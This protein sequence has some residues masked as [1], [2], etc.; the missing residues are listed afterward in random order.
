M[1]TVT[2]TVFLRTR[3]APL[4]VLTGQNYMS[5]CFFSV[6]VLFFNGQTELTIAV[7]A[8]PAAALEPQPSRPTE[9]L[10]LGA[11]STY[12]FWGVDS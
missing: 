3:T 5:V 10:R 2:G 4:S 9:H 7:R 8:P 6:M 11:H 12:L 1:A